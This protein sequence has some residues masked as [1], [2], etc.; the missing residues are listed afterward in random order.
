MLLILIKPYNTLFNNQVAFSF[1]MVRTSAMCWSTAGS[2]YLVLAVP[3]IAL[4]VSSWDLTDLSTYTFLSICRTWGDLLSWLP[5]SVRS[6]GS[7]PGTCISQVSVMGL[8]SQNSCNSAEV[9]HRSS[10]KIGTRRP[11]FSIVP[12]CLPGVKAICSD[13]VLYQLSHL[14]ARSCL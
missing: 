2:T 8:L 12:V 7:G 9:H 4:H 10:H 5:G 1:T 11:V 6:A 14:S 3:H 13:F